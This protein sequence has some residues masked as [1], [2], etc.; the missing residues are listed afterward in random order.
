M[1]EG[2]SRRD[3]MKTA[4]VAGAAA[5]FAARAMAPPAT[6]RA[7]GNLSRG[8]TVLEPFNYNGVR[9]LD[10]RLKKQYLETRQYYFSLPDDDILKG[11]RKR[12][13]LP[14]PGNDMGTW[15]GPDTGEVFGQWLSGM[16][17]MYKATG[18][19]AMREKA[20]YLMKEWAKT[21]E[22]D[23][24]SYWPTVSVE[25]RL[26]F[27]QYD[28]MVCGLVDMYEYCGEKDALPALERITDWA[29][30]NLDRS[31]KPAG[32]LFGRSGF[33]AEWYTL[34][35][36]LYRA[37]LLTGNSKYKA[38]ADEWHYDHFW[39]M[40]TGKVPLN[41]Q[42]FHAYSHLNS[43]SS[44]AMTFA[45]TGDPEYLKTIVN[46]YEHFQ[47]IQCFATGGYGPG[48]MLVA[49]DGSLGV[50]LEREVNTFETPCGVWAAFK[51]A[52]YL[53]QF[54]GEARF[55]DWIEKLVYNGIGAALP[56]APA[57]KTFYY[58]EYCLGSNTP[59]ASA[60]KS[61]YWDPYPCCSGTYIQDVADYHNVIYFK[62]AS[63]LFV[64]LFV[65]SEV[66]WNQAGT[67][68]KVVQETDY[69]ES[70]TTSLTVQ[71]SSSATFD[72][73][74]RVPSW[75]DG[76]T[77]Q[78]NGSRVEVASRPGTWA[79]ITRTWHSGDRVSIQI[80][81]C[82]RIVP[83][84]AQHP[85]RVALMCGPVVLVQDGKYSSQPTR[86]PSD[87]DVANWITRSGNPPEFQ[88]TEGK[89]TDAPFWPP[90]L[91]KFVPF[92]RFQPEVPYR[93]YFDLSA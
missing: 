87:G 73:K 12:A 51:L 17:R 68:V 77:V 80:P 8:K 67:D 58:S 7:E 2:K 30:K 43:L 24:T 28:K 29:V 38:F 83:V 21:I 42:R 44:A 70:E 25:P 66:T 50:S 60:R 62:D 22:P 47:Q 84:D 53:M 76:I 34:A 86:Q 15:G 90:P 13:G 85:H 19:G 39:G 20:V 5:P 64:N 55:G 82:V 36:N 10:G 65:P 4:L 40:F 72:L 27:Y 26:T 6:A 57:G 75:S 48:E 33:P 54:T 61:Y 14:A 74:F 16:A 46:A 91:G 93:M 63:G 1:S 78:I 59:F 3:F 89:S 11:F 32:S 49:P 79:T 18:D 31:R 37:Y 23:G 56:M 41:V 52:R 45:V 92:Y 69:P 88:L 9:L 81:L 35:E 71:V